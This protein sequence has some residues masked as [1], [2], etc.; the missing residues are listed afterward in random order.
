MESEA[1]C[2]CERGGHNKEFQKSITIFQVKVSGLDQS[3]FRN[4]DGRK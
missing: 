2:V 1:S 4:R 3:S